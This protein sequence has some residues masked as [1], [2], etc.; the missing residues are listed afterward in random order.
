MAAAVESP[1]TTART[2]GNGRVAACWGAVIGSAPT[3]SSRVFTLRST[4]GV[5]EA[6]SSTPPT[7][8]AI[9]T[10]RPASTVLTIVLYD[11]RPIPA[12]AIRRTTAKPAAI[13]VS[14]SK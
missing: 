4:P 8:T 13:S 14:H 2:P 6:V 11:C 10:A 12:T 5:L 3:R 7:L 1:I 9:T